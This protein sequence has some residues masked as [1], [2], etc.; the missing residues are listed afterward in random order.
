MRDALSWWVH[1]AGELQQHDHWKLLY[2]AFSAITDDLQLPP[3]DLLDGTFRFL[4]HTWIECRDGLMSEGVPAKTVR[5]A[6]MSLWRQA[7]L[8]YMEK[9]DPGLRP[10]LVSKKP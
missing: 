4:G 9:V 1:W 10:L 3:G 8:Q 5:V 6:E 7:L 2:A